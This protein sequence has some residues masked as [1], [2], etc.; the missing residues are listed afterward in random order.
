MEHLAAVHE[1]I[2]YDLGARPVPRGLIE[3]NNKS[4]A[5]EHRAKDNARCTDV[6]EIRALVEEHEGATLVIVIT[7]FLCGLRDLRSD[8][9]MW[10]E[11]TAA[12]AGEQGWVI[13][14]LFHFK[15]Q[16]VFRMR[17][18]IVDA[19]GRTGKRGS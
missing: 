4:D 10:I 1:D 17:D 13:I 5:P 15:P 14:E 6:H 16:R 12:P 11:C 2:V 9:N 19:P 3:G 8:A 18:P 7:K